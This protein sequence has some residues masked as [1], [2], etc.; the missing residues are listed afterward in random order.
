MN[1]SS[2][3]QSHYSQLSEGELLHVAEERSGLTPEADECLSA[4]LLR[5][6]LTDSDV[7]TYARISQHLE[8]RRAT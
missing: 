4:E 6:G 3:V 8:K 7:R 5:R 1:N 2:A